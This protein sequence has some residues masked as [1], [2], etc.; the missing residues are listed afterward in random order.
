MKVT[1]VNTNRYRHPPVIP[2]GLEYLVAPLERA[3]HAV[4]ICDL[5]AAD[6]PDADLADFLDGSEP[7]VIGFTVRNVDTSV[8]TDRRFF[9]DDIARLIGTARG[10]CGAVTVAGGSATLCSTGD[11]KQYIDVDYLVAGPG[12]RAFPEL[13]EAIERGS[14]APGVIDGWA[15]GIIPGISHKRG[16]LV[17]YRP[18]LEGGNPAGIEFRKGCDWGCEFCVE[19]A[20]PVIKRDVTA[21]IGEARALAQTGAGMFFLCDPEVN[22]DLEDTSEFLSALA[23]ADLPLEWTGYFRP[24]PFDGR[25]AGLVTASGCRK[26]T[27]WAASRH[28]SREEGPYGPSDVTTFLDLCAHEGIKVAVDLLIGYPGESLESVEKTLE[29]LSEARPATVGIYPYIRL[30]ENTPVKAAA[31]HGRTGG[32]LLGEVED[33]PGMLKPV[34]YTGIDP[35]WLEERISGDP[36]FELAGTQKTVNYERT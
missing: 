2:I 27:L 26:L 9:L 17:D 23:K 14:A 24:A 36:L 29:L 4:D 1:L 7:D 31:A 22:L 33:N 34:F 25:M 3:G 19:R 8:F 16:T 6:N 5:S 21:V 30:F 20:R 10:R 32:L 35:T 15:R 18:Y 13:L 28:L 12:E 11:L